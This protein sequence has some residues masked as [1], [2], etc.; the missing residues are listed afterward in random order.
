MES[1]SSWR[2]REGIKKLRKKEKKIAGTI[3]LYTRPYSTGYRLSGIT[4]YKIVTWIEDL[5]VK[6]SNKEP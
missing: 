5:M 2:A 3:G 1:S 6:I 4:R